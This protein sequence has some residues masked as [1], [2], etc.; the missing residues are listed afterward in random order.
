MVADEDTLLTLE[1]LGIPSFSARGLEQTLDPIDSAGEFDRDVN[2]NLVDLSP[3]Q[4]KKYRST[5]SCQDTEGPA[6]DGVPIGA[7]VTVHCVAELPY[8]TEDGTPSREAVE[9]SEREVGAW[10]YYRPILTMVVVGFSI[11]RNEWSRTVSWQLDLE[12]Q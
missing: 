12:E 2:G 9:D 4:F 11:S 6:L 8:L 5:V 3:P 10:T 7:V 1:G